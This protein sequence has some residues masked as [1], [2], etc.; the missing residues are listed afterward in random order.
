MWLFKSEKETLEFDKVNDNMVYK[1]EECIADGDDFELQ[2]IVDNKVFHLKS[3][4]L[5]PIIAHDDKLDYDIVVSLEIDDVLFKLEQYIKG[6]LLANIESERPN[7]DL[8]TFDSYVYNYFDDPEPG[9]EPNAETELYVEFRKI[10]NNEH[11][12]IIG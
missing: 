1:V 12:I 9:A 11:E 4:Y 10:N 8:F 5:E 3:Q 2:Y 7:G 6:E